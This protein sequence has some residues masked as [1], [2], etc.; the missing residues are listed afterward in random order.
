[1]ILMA[2][3]FLLALLLGMSVGVEAQ[4]AG[5]SEAMLQERLRALEKK[6]ALLERQLDLAQRPEAGV[7]QR[8]AALEDRLAD[9]AARWEAPA[10]PVT[11]KAAEIGGSP[12]PQPTAAALPVAPQIAVSTVPQA[13]ASEQMRTTPYAGYM[14]MHLNSAKQ[15]PTLLDFHRLVLL[16]GHSFSPRMKFWSELEVE[17]AFIEGAEPG[18]E[19][20]VEQAYVDF[21]VKPRL[22][23]R[24]GILLAPVGIVNE[25]HEPPSFF[26]VERPFVDTVLI[27]STWFDAGFGIHGDLG[28]GLSYRVY[29]MAPPDASRF[30]AGEGIRGGRQQG[31]LSVFNT[32]GV[33]GRFEYRGVPRLTLGTSFFT[34]NT[35]FNLLNVDPWLNLMEFDARYRRGRA[36]FRGQF[37]QYWLNQTGNLNRT[38][39]LQTGVNPNIARSALGYY[40]EAGYHLVPYTLSAD[41]APFFRYE[42][43]NTQ[44][45]MAN[46]FT[47]LPQFDR[48]AYTLGLSFRPHPDIAIKTDYQ[49]LRNRSAVVPISNR[50][51]MGIGWWF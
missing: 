1:M 40:L 34:A 21:F 30:S 2:R 31:L 5:S 13:P 7:E 45:R 27:P 25:R 20:A 3:V 32:P 15:E 26:G 24:G 49:F 51:N 42:K 50:F 23:F 29:A 48:S 9:L 10:A 22:N 18:G 28:R 41:V 14:E 39:E 19:I 33:T 38:I 44:H 12:D 35:G 46:G 36:E 37:A 17:H 6:L 16:F 8:L 4:E 11:A 47:P 43:F